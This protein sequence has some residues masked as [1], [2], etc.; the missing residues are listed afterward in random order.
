ML[1]QR[2]TCECD[3]GVNRKGRDDTRKGGVV[4]WLALNLY[5]VEVTGEKKKGGGFPGIVVLHEKEE[6]KD[7]IRTLEM[8]FLT[9]RSPQINTCQIAWCQFPCI[10]LS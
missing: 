3:K 6:V 8:L 2:W 10:S 9:L 7:F 5:F 4:F 1:T